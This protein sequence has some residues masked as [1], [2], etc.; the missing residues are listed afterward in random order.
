MY[1]TNSNLIVGTNHNQP[2]ICGGAV[3]LGVVA[4]LTV[5][6]ASGIR[7]IVEVHSDSTFNSFFRYFTQVGARRSTKRFLRNASRNEG[8]PKLGY[9]QPG[10]ES[11]AAQIEKYADPNNPI[12]KKTIRIM[13]R[14][15][16][17]KM[18]AV[19]PDQLGL[20]KMASL[21]IYGPVA[22]AS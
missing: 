1:S 13:Q 3:K 22:R 15:T 11:V 17:R 6:R 2:A 9:Y 16:Y 19:S 7:M 14:R 20:T 21:P 8:L 5:Y 10:L 18:I 4:R 12:I